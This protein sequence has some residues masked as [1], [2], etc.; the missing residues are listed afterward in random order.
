MAVGIA[1]QRIPET[2]DHHDSQCIAIVE[3]LVLDRV[4]EHQ[5]LALLPL[6]F[7]EPDPQ[8]AAVRHK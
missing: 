5:R 3:G 7:L 8:S 6:P 4:I 2:E 1:Q